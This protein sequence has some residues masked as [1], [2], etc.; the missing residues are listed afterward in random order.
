MSEW[1]V[2]RRGAEPVGP[3]STETLVRGVLEKKVPEDALV[4]RVGEREWQRVAQI[5]ELWEKIHPEQFKTSVTAKPW[6]KEAGDS[7]PPAESLSDADS[8]NDDDA[9]RIYAAPILAIGGNDSGPSASTDAS[10]AESGSTPTIPLATHNN[11]M[12]HARTTV[13][14][15]TDK[16]EVPRPAAPAITA[17]KAAAP[18]FTVPGSTAAKGSKAAAGA[19]RSQ[20]LPSGPKP[21]IAPPRFGVDRLVTTSPIAAGA[22]AAGAMISKSPSSR[23]PR[24]D[25]RPPSSNTSNSHGARPAADSLKV[26]ATSTQATKPA[27]S[28]QHAAATNPQAARPAAN[29][30]QATA[31]TS[32]AAKPAAS[33]Q[34]A[35]ATKLK[36]ARPPANPQPAPVTKLQGARPP[37]N[38]QPA[39]AAKPQTIEKGRQPIPPVPAAIIPLPEGNA[40]EPVWDDLSVPLTQTRPDGPA[41][42]KVRNSQPSVP[43][44]PP[45]AARRQVAP[46]QAASVAPP[47]VAAARPP[48]HEQ[49][50]S[51]AAAPATPSADADDDAETVIRNVQL[52]PISQPPDDEATVVRDLQ[53]T[54]IAQPT[55]SEA[56]IVEDVRPVP[57]SQPADDDQ[58]TVIRRVQPL[59]AVRQNVAVSQTTL[60]S[61]GAP[62]PLDDLEKLAGRQVRDRVEPNQDQP[63]VVPPEQAK[64]TPIETRQPVKDTPVESRQPVFDHQPQDLYDEDD[65]VPPARAASYAS[66]HDPPSARDTAHP[67]PAAGTPAPPTVIVAQQQVP[68][69]VVGNTV[70]AHTELTRP[71]LRSIRPPGTVQIS[72]GALIVGAL[73][74]V[75]MVLTA[76]L[77]LR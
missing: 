52:A 10:S 30:P 58:A 27:A 49:A 17:T 71:A 36:G 32:Q 77:L 42:A 45:V 64:V 74:I 37:A 60:P 1:W 38:A 14:K 75:V 65:E 3:V 55:D 20:E 23:P 4:C 26:A 53:A 57:V 7:S 56:T 29:P 12:A 50:Q 13:A 31:T 34:P 54:P 25:S 33:P 8:D 59:P 72:V 70:Q 9:T 44:E 66:A 19:A 62:P 35:A 69:D 51:L 24:P 73:A 67:R 21:V 22:I 2:G 48:S 43:S 16:A 18:G 47:P 6:F 63:N 76:V 15:V 46:V 28:S 61:H 11:Q 5:D 41:A 40:A 39:G 68:M